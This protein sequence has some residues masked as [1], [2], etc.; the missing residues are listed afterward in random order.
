M[1]YSG[2]LVFYP[3]TD[4]NT[5]WYYVDDICGTRWGLPFIPKDMSD[6][7]WM[8]DVFQEMQYTRLYVPLSEYTPNAGYYYWYNGY[9]APGDLGIT[10][11]PDGYDEITI[12][13]ADGSYSYYEYIDCG[14]HDPV[15]NP[16]KDV[17]LVDCMIYITLGYICE[18][19]IPDQEAYDIH[20]YLEPVANRSAV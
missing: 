12:T 17:I 5:Y 18:A 1:K 16:D 13:G 14:V 6:W 2:R 8:K 7:Y 15:A 11:E 4:T 9:T 10:I 3:P 19:G 20:P